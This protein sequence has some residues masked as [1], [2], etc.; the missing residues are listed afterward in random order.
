MA[1]KFWAR[2]DE[3]V[4]CVISRLFH[5]PGA[6]ISIQGKQLCQDRPESSRTHPYTSSPHA[7]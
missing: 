4:A 1:E 6:D 7:E 3:H 5:D 2:L